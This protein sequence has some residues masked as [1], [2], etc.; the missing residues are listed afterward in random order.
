MK[1]HTELWWEIAKGLIVL[2][3][4]VALFAAVLVWFPTP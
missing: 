4:M 2:L 3:F 1:Y